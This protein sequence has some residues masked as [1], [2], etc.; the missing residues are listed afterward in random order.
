M[1]FTAPL[2]LVAPSFKFLLSATRTG[3]SKKEAFRFRG[4]SSIMAGQCEPSHFLQHVIVM[5]HGDRM[6]NVE[7]L[8]VSTADRPWDPPLADAGKVRAWCTGKQIRKLNFPI[9]RVFVSPFL[10][11]IQTASEAVTALA[12]VDVDNNA[13]TSQNAVIDPSKLK[14]SIEYGLCEVLNT[15]AIR[16]EI[17]PKNGCWNLELSQL[18]AMLPAGTVDHTVE[19]V[20]KELP[21]WQEETQEARSRYEKVFTALANKFP[22][23]NLLVVTHGEGVGVAISS[24][25]KNA[26]V[27]DV[28]YCAYA[29][30]CR[31]ITF[32]PGEK[33]VAGNFELLTGNAMNGICWQE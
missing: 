26:I 5:R 13:E 17:A 18:E 6:D 33:F 24:L 2:S 8:W 25:L 15:E 12:A 4:G 16:G 29:H 21:K 14:V 9:S 23:E 30:S 31:Q 19:R 11:C 28:E 27:Y 7:P 20:Y 32:G 10:R 3:F 22:R 1:H